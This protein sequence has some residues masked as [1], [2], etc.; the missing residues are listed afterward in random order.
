MRRGRIFRSHF[1][2]SRCLGPSPSLGLGLKV[3]EWPA[4]LSISG[5][6][7]GEGPKLTFPLL[8]SAIALP[9][10][11]FLSRAS[12]CSFSDGVGTALAEGE[13]RQGP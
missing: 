3:V 10:Q 2:S 9:K 13:R 7:Q 1:G 12:P 11:M 8:V 6:A 4:R 5:P